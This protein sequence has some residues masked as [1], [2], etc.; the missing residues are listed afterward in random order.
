MTVNLSHFF[1]FMLPFLASLLVS[2]SLIILITRFAEVKKEFRLLAACCMVSFFWNLSCL[3]LSLFPGSWTAALLVEITRPLPVVVIPLVLHLVH[4]YLDA[5]GNTIAL[6][7]AYILSFLMI[8]VFWIDGNEE[9]RMAPFFIAS[10]A[11]GSAY[12]Y[13]RLF[14][15]P[16]HSAGR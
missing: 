11:V 10:S 7:I 4:R 16:D 9:I 5:K 13:L 3:S 14:S 6:W 12:V 15:I 8:G 1:P 2:A